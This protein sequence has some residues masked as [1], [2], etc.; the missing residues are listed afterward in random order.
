MNLT[1]SVLQLDR[2]AVQALR[3][4][5]AYSLHRVV[6]SLFDDVRSDAE[7]AA[8]H[9]SGILYA[10]QGGD[11]QHR[12]ILLLSDR[13]PAPHIDGRYGT[14]R[15]RPIAEDF[16]RTRATASKSSSTPP[17]ATAPAASCCQ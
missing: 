15:S 5:D 3:V 14:V 10:D 7:K 13:P 16:W 8:S 4:T 6:Y 2:T 1:A 17:G 11:F 12:T 9:A